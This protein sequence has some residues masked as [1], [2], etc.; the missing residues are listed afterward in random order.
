MAL[1]QVRSLRSTVCPAHAEACWISFMRR[2]H[3]ACGFRLGITLS[4]VYGIYSAV[5]SV[6]I[7]FEHVMHFQSLMPPF[8]SFLLPW[9]N[10]CS[11]NKAHVVSPPLGSPP[12]ESKPL[13][14]SSN[15][16]SPFTGLHTTCFHYATCHPASQSFM[17]VSVLLAGLW[18][19]PAQHEVSRFLILLSEPGPMPYIEWA[20]SQ[21][22]AV[23]D[24]AADLDPP[25]ALLTKW[26]GRLGSRARGR[27][28]TV[29]AL[30]VIE[31]RR[32]LGNVEV[33]GRNTCGRRER[34]NPK[35]P[36]LRLK[37]SQLLGAGPG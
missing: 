25:G 11:S 15:L 3:S 23:D 19:P 12:G 10:S 24:R 4:L 29:P 32:G 33:F 7:I 35:L 22:G 36:I 21:G 30:T 14:F 2:C 17:D 26:L 37:V 28:G 8:Q 5:S 34:G 1:D 27:E 20:M 16:V 18:A 31:K 9:I 13:S 6:F